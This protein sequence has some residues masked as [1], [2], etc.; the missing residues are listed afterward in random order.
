MRNSLLELIRA[1]FEGV[2]VPPAVVREFRL[3]EGRPGSSAL[4]QAIEKEWLSRRSPPTPRL[5][6]PSDKT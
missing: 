2:L 1:Q 3:E 5:S 6:A 4:R